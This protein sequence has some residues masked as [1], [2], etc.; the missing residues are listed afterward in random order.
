MYRVFFWSGLAQISPAALARGASRTGVLSSP[1]IGGFNS[2]TG[3]KR[4]FRKVI[5]F[6]SL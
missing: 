3:S 5:F 2:S 4:G 6:P 1:Q